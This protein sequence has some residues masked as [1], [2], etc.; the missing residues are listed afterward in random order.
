MNFPTY[1]VSFEKSNFDESVIVTGDIKND[2]S[3]DYNLAMF[4][5]FLYSRN[6]RVGAGVIKVYD[7]KKDITKPFRA[8]VLSDVENLKL[9]MIDRY[10]V[11]IEGGY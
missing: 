6:K 3:H 10:E 1:E 11:I 4:R 2:S 9:S 5:I 7:F 8:F